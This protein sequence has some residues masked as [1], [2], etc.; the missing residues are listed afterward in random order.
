MPFF[1]YDNNIV[2]IVA[3]NFNYILTCSQRQLISLHMTV[4][5]SKAHWLLWSLYTIKC[6][7]FFSSYKF[8]LAIFISVLLLTMLY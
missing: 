1:S 2:F 3:I 7:L 4:T 6:M 5:N 8:L